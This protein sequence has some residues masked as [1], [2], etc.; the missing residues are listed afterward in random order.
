MT[1][2]FTG[3][4]MA[5]ILIAG[6][7]VVV[8]VNFAMAR[9]AVSTF[10]GVV[11]ENS[12]AASQKYNGWLANARAQQA[13]GWSAT[14]TR[15]AGDRPMVET[16]A[17]PAGAVIEATARHPLGREADRKL[18]FLPDGLQRQISREVLPPGR[19]T[20]RLQITTSEHEWRSEE[21]L[22]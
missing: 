20:I 14:V 16:A 8:V 1:R 17:V 15:A 12:Y 2:P 3:R 21:D 7:G 9:F 10:G 11:V 6:F 13:L 5:A 22:R 4:H 18:T 19:W